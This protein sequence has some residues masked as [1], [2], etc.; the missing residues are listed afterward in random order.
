M[1]L[2]T[3]YSNISQ[4]FTFS[5]VP[6]GAASTYTSLFRLGNNPPANIFIPH[7]SGINGTGSGNA[8]GTGFLPYNCVGGFAGIGATGGV[9]GIV[10]GCI[11]LQWPTSGN[12]YLAK[13]EVSSNVATST[14]I[15]YD[16]L[17]HASGF[18]TRTVGIETG[19]AVVGF[20][21]LP[22]R[23]IYGSSSGFG[24]EI[25]GEL[26]MAA[27]GPNGHWI[28]DYTDSLGVPR[29]AAHFKSAAYALHT[30][31]PFFNA[32][33]AYVGV[34]SITSFSAT[35]GTTANTNLTL[36]VLRRIAE[37]PIRNVNEKYVYNILALGKPV[38]PSGAALF[39]MAYGA[40]TL[41]NGTLEFS[42][43]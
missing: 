30:M 40:S 28:V 9:T 1:D 22:P 20:G 7:F 34:K 39:M 33:G 5:K 8:K 38:I 41:V 23:D 26:T 19:Q 13:A 36:V 25:W 14:L 35:G 3:F 18:N 21:V 15:F 37:L 29:Q 24:C 6:A 11:P 31:I 4:R 12:L 16:R 17:W 42:K 32:S 2:E 43:D 10:S 27:T